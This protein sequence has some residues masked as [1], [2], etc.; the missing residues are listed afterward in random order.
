MRLRSFEDGIM[1]KNPR[2]DHVEDVN[3]DDEGSF[4]AIG[5]F[6]DDK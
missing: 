5:E 1:S 3:S 4:G 6:A 2:K